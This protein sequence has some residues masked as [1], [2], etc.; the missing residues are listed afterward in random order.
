MLFGGQNKV[1]IKNRKLL[2]RVLRFVANRETFPVSFNT[3]LRLRVNCKKS[4]LELNGKNEFSRFHFQ[5]ILHS[6]PAELRNLQRKKKT[7]LRD[8]FLIYTE[9]A[10]CFEVILSIFSEF[11]QV[12]TP[13]FILEGV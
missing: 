13:H 2:G 7:V 6:F 10:A 9:K 12:G 4:S 5:P 8:R 3:S 11:Y 1:E